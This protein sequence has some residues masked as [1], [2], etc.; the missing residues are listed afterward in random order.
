MKRTEFLSIAIVIAALACAPARPL[1]TAA[2][3]L[4]GNPAP[5]YPDSLKATGLT[6]Q[7]VAQATVDSTGAV[8]PSTIRI[9]STIHPGFNSAVTETLARWRFRPARQD[10]RSIGQV[11]Q[12]PFAFKLRAP[13]AEECRSLLAREESAERAQTGQRLGMGERRSLKPV[14]SLTPGARPSSV[15]TVAEF[16]VDSTG[17]PDVSSLR[18]V[19]STIPFGEASNDL[20][21]VLPRWRFEPARAGGC[22]FGAI[23]RHEFVY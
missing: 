2:V 15:R 21:R 1:E 23:A 22:A 6:G 16:F 4:A 17:A 13:N 5:A 8:V 10:E 12:I 20:R 14:Q 3:P 7:V 11:V 19:E 9:I 18:V